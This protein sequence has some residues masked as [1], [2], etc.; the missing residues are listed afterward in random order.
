MRRK[1]AMG[2][3]SLMVLMGTAIVCWG[4]EAAPQGPGPGQ[5]QHEWGDGQHRMGQGSGQFGGERREGGPGGRGMG[6]QRGGHR[7]FGGEVV[8]AFCAWRRLRVRQY[9]ALTDEQVGR[10]HQIGLS[11]RKES[12]QTRADMELRHIE[13]GELMRA[14][15]P[16]HDAIMQKL[17]EGDAPRQD[18]KAA[19][20]NHALGPRGAYTGAADQDQDVYAEP[21]R[22]H[23]TPARDAAAWRP[24]RRGSVASSG[25]GT[26]GGP[27]KPPAPTPPAQ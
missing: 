22:R 13:L 25:W 8:K 15:N 5:G 11:A 7:G 23:G 20:G 2:T 26:S 19:R 3:L 16:D 10:L 12:V 17:D 27:R 21:R 4:E 24:G 6:W 1:F 18:G 14:D 9:L